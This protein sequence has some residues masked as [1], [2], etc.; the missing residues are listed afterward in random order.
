M[1]YE[2]HPIAVTVHLLKQKATDTR[3][4]PVGCFPTYW[5]GLFKRSL[6][7]IGLFQGRRIAVWSGEIKR[8]S[9]AF[10]TLF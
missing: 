8:A 6:A 7:V 2:G 10:L 9:V 1:G 4:E 3:G 5:I